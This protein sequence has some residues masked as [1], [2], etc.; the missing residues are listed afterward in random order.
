MVLQFEEHQLQLVAVVRLKS[1]AMW[2]P[3]GSQDDELVL[4]S[5]ERVS[6]GPE[7]HWLRQ[8]VD[9][10]HLHLIHRQRVHQKRNLNRR[11]QSYLVLLVRRNPRH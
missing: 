4:R 6:V 11:R 3:I 8:H 9:A 7:R 5:L 2:A 1:G 10:V